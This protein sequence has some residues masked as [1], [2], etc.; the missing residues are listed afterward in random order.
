MGDLN[1]RFWGENGKNPWPKHAKTCVSERCALSGA[2][3]AHSRE[4][5]VGRCTS[6]ARRPL[7][8]NARVVL[9]SGARGKSCRDPMR[10]FEG[11]LL[12]F[13]FTLL[14]EHTWLG[15]NL[16]FLNGLKLDL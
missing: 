8:D 14:L 9:C 1:I 4:D 3:G 12:L 7:Q 2:L 11:V 16:D 5:S 13:S 10:P 15:R 6:G